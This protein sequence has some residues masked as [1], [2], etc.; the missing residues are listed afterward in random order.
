MHVFG[1]K[2]E[3]LPRK[4]KS[5]SIFW[6]G[7]SKL[8]RMRNLIFGTKIEFKNNVISFASTCKNSCEKSG[9]VQSKVLRWVILVCVFIHP[10]AVDVCLFSCDQLHKGRGTSVQRFL[11]KTGVTTPSKMKRVLVRT[12]S[13]SARERQQL[14]DL[15]GHFNSIKKHMTSFFRGES[16]QY[17][18]KSLKGCVNW[19][20]IIAFS[21]FYILH[22]SS[23]INEILWNT[24]CPELDFKIG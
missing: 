12:S 18:N 6:R 7:N 13:K 21:E 5:T 11:E 16:H 3:F 17:K 19:V 10:V 2:I 4:F 14:S 24:G 15:E 9:G 8:S 1:A 22:Q 23:K 20:W